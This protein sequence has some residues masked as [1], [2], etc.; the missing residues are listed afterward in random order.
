MGAARERAP[1]VAPPRP[2][3]PHALAVRLEER[4]PPRRRCAA[5]T[6]ASAS[7]TP[8]ASSSAA[9]RPSACPL[10]A[11]RAAHRRARHEYLLA[12]VLEGRLGSRRMSCSS[13]SWAALRPAA[14]SVSTVLSSASTQSR[15]ARA[16]LR[17]VAKGCTT[18]AARRLASAA[19]A[20]AAASWSIARAQPVRRDRTERRSRARPIRALVFFRQLTAGRAISPRDQRTEPSGE[21]DQYAAARRAAAAKQINDLKIS[22]AECEK[23]TQGARR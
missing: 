5:A 16:W 14:H 18:R 4:W 7:R 3:A 8:S 6:A 20:S 23:A 1:R 12:L 9:S 2:P 11:P 10:C 15:V 21:P 17:S 13:P 19:R 22:R